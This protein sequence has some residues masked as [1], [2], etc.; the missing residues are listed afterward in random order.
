MPCQNGVD[1]PQCFEYYNLAYAYDAQEKTT[2][3]YLWAL[4]GSFSGGIPGY[5]SCCIQCGECED[6][7]PQDFAIRDYLQNVAD[8]FG[9]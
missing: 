7:C 3:V 9:K 2:G 8:F 5:A 6:K 4:N 1:I